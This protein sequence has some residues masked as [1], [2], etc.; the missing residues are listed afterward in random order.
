MMLWCNVHSG[1]IVGFALTGIYAGIALLRGILL[2]ET[3]ER[4]RG[5]AFAGVL[6]VMAV[7]TLVNPSGARL[8]TEI[9]HHLGMASTR[10][11]A[12]FQ[13]PDFHPS[14]VSIFAFEL[15]ILL[16]VA[17]AAVSRRSLPSV[18]IA[19]L[20]FFLHEGL[21]SVRHMNLF[22]MVAAPILARE[23]SAPFAEALP[24]LAARSREIVAEQATLRSALVYVPALAAVFLALAP[25][26]PFPRTL[27]GLQLTRGAA[28]FIAQRRGSFERAFNTDDLGGPLIYRFWP[29]LRVFVDD[30][31]FVY[32]DDFIMKDYFA[33]LYGKVG[34]QDVL[35]RHGLRAAIVTAGTSCAT[36]LRTSPEWKVVYEDEKNVLF[37]RNAGEPVRRV[38]AP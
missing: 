1:F 31:I 13:S 10:Y 35:D 18:E 7:A 11:F 37:L 6:V 21:E 36:L 30:R 38:S 17:V 2:G 9:V 26:L 23:L 25:V 27:D 24:R 16:V 12:E 22:A 3:A 33:V 15:M 5:M 28:E 32:G 8:H 14:H 29:E 19:L 20:V 34:W 4:R